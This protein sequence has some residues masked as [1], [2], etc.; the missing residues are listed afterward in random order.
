MTFFC[1]LL[2][3]DNHVQGKQVHL[4]CGD[5]SS[6]TRFLEI[7]SNMYFFKICFLFYLFFF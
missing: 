1:L 6:L 2:E 4:E 3:M 5:P 7:A